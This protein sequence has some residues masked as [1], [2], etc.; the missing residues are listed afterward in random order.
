MSAWLKSPGD[1]SGTKLPASCLMG[2]RYYEL[3]ID[4]KKDSPDERH[5]WLVF[6]MGSNGTHTREYTNDISIHKRGGHAK[7][8][9][10]NCT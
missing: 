10:S 5:S 3:N 4:V 7:C 9:R 2:F 8:N 6:R 1:S